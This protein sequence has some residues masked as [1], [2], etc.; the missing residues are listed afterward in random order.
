[1]RIKAAAV[2]DQPL[3]GRDRSNRQQGKRSGP[4]NPLLRRIRREVVRR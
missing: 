1:M 3:F 4:P 2:F